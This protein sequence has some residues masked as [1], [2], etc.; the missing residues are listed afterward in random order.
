MWHF[1]FAMDLICNCGRTVRPCVSMYLFA[2][3]WR[4]NIG[5]RDCHR[6]P[7]SL[8]FHTHTH[9]GKSQWEHNGITVRVAHGIPCAVVLGLYSETNVNA[10]PV[11]LHYMGSGKAEPTVGSTWGVR[12]TTVK[13]FFTV[14]WSTLGPCR[15][16]GWSSA[17]RQQWSSMFTID[18]L[19]WIVMVI[20]SLE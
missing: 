10:S 20:K 7:E 17:T 16:V 3:S 11:H 4:E 2:I 8:S 13:K 6:T 19:R 18:D 15:K 1:W 9:T 14:H 12:R 5:H